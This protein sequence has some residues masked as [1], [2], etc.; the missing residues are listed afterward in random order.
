MLP[1]PDSSKA[2]PKSDR[3]LLT[4]S[5]MFDTIPYPHNRTVSKAATI[6]HHDNMS[7][8]R[9]PE[10]DIFLRVTRDKQQWVELSRRPGATFFHSWEWNSW[11]APLI[12]SR[13]IP[14]VVHAGREPIGIAPLMLR[15]RAGFVLANIVPFSFLGPVVP[16]EQL[17][18]TCSALRTW[19]AR[20][21]IGHLRVCLHSDLSETTGLLAAAGLK[22]EPYVTYAIDLDVDSE[23][24]V[25]ESFGRDA[26]SAVRRSIRHNVEIRESSPHELEELLP[27]VVEAALGERTKYVHRVGARLAES[28]PPF[29]LRASTATADGRALGVLLAV[30]GPDVIGWIGGVEKASQYTQAN[31]ALVWDQIRWAYG[32]GARRLDML[33]APDPNIAG[34][35]MKYRPTL[36]RHAQGTW[37]SPAFSAAQRLREWRSRR[38]AE[39]D[40]DEAS[41]PR[42]PANPAKMTG[43]K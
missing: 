35:K 17:V 39:H 28:S 25:F 22:E 16:Q 37:K 29:P 24:A 2:R 5:A 38:R 10:S 26:R 36:L 43:S 11:V 18:P 12:G 31:S 34:Y 13:F 1:G 4:P 41:D 20:R 27:A 21:Q 42:D 19:A 8:R 14:L 6:Q 9:A 3:R 32:Q 33:G 40:R 30:G 15:R 23:D 7:Q